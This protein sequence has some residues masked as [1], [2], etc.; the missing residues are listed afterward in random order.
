PVYIAAR[1]QDKPGV[2]GPNGKSDGVEPEHVYAGRHAKMSIQAFGYDTDGNRG[3]TFGL[4]NGQLRDNDDEL[5]IGG[6]RVSA[7]SEFEAAE[8]AGDDGKSTD[9]LFD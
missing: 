3:V 6:G 7:E 2:V 4:I 5:V 8:G 9:N 1:S